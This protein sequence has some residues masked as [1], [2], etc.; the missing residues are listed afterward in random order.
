ML[1]GSKR[2]RL[3]FLL[4]LFL[5][6]P[7]VR[8][9]ATATSPSW[10]PALQQIMESLVLRRRR[11]SLQLLQFLPFLFRIRWILDLQPWLMSVPLQSISLLTALLEVQLQSI[12][13]LTAVQQP[14][15]ELNK[16]SWLNNA[17]LLLIGPVLAAIRSLQRAL[18][19]ADGY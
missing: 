8:I 2:H 4:T 13:R 1:T 5:L 9:L 6:W 3:V 18:F 14:Q 16:W 11:L 17:L 12:P 7:L 15:P 10:R 19:P